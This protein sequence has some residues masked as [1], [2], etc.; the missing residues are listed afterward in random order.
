MRDTHLAI[1]NCSTALILGMSVTLSP[2]LAEP[3]ARGATPAGAIIDRKSGEEVRFVD[4]TDWRN[5][6]LKQDLLGG[7]LLRT[8]AV[9][10]LA[11]LFADHTQVRLGR[12]SALQVKKMGTT[13]DTVL[14]LT[15]GSMWAR[16]QRG[17]QAL[18]VETPAAAAAIRG[19]DWTL[20]VKGD[21]TSLIVL[22]GKI[23]FKNAF[24]SVEVAAGEG[25][26]AS[27]GQA[28]RKL[29]IVNTKDRQQM[30]VYLTLRSGFTFMPA[31][32]LP[33]RKMREEYA[34]ISGLPAETRST[35]DWLTLAEARMAIE[36]QASALD[37]LA[38]L[39][40]RQ[41]SAGQRARI[42]FID[43]LV[44]GSGRRYAE[45]ADLFAKA[46]RGLDPKRRAVAAYGG[47]FARS[48][49]DPNRIEAPPRTISTPYSDIMQA[50]T[51]GFLKDIPA[52]IEVIRQSEARYRDDP[53]LPAVRALL[54]GLDGDRE[55]MQAATDRA[56]S[57]DPENPDA[58]FARATLK[59][60]YLG[61]RKGAV[62][63]FKA[64][65]AQAPGESSAW[66]S[67]GL[68]YGDMGA[69]REQEAALRKAIELDPDDPVG[70]A[71]MALY[72]LDQGRVKDA[73]VMI[74]KALAVDPAFDVALVA[75]GRYFLQTGEPDKAIEDLLAGATAN[76]GYSQA[77]LMLGIGH[78]I[79]G[80]RDPS[81]Q[82]IE[83]ADRLDRN[84]PV[85]A[86]LRT[87]I[88]IDDYDADTAIRNA[89]DFLRRSRAAGGESAAIGA[90]QD[91]GSTLNS[92]FRLQGMNAWGRYYGD[93]TF[94]PFNGGGYIDQMI[95]GQANPYANSYIYGQGA[96]DIADSS[97]GF[98]SRIQG[99]LLDPH[100]IAAP[101]RRASILRS[102]FIETSLGGGFT[103]SGG[104]TRR[105]GELEVQAYGND[106]LPT[107]FAADINWTE[108][109]TSGT[110]QS[111]GAFFTESELLDASV[112]LTSSLTENDRLVVYGSRTRAKLDGSGIGYDSL[113][114]IPFS[115][116]RT[117]ADDTVQTDA[118][119]GL[120][121]TF[122]YRNIANAALLYTGIDANASKRVSLDLP[123]PFDD[124]D[125]YVSSASQR[126][127]IAAVN[128][129]I[130]TDDLTLRYGIEGGIVDTDASF[131]ANGLQLSGG[132]ERARVGL[133]YA[134][135]L[136]DLSPDLK[137]EYGLFGTV[138][139]GGQDAGTRLDPRFGVAWAPA[140]N[141]WLRGAFMRNG[142]DFSTPT[143]SPVATL[144]LQANRFNLTGGSV[145]TFAFEWDAQWSDRF[146]TAVEYQ[147]QDLN[148]FG[149]AY[150]TTGMPIDDNIDLSDGTIDRAS[151][152]TNTVLGGGFG[153][154]T[155][156]A[157]ARSYNGDEDSTG[158]GST[159][160]FVPD[161]T[162]QIALTWVNDAHVKATLAANYVGERT[163]T[164]DGARLNDYWTLDASL[165][166][167]PFDK[168]ISFEAAAYNLLNSDFELTP[169]VPGWGPSFKGMLKVT[170]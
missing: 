126:N 119:V 62:E 141:H 100:M 1:L 70:Y 129:M 94:D 73:K 115:F 113:F 162:G 29:V 156:L 71:N 72:Y 96:A 132:A 17:G 83:N 116:T 120:S 91:A 32:P 40:E 55:A 145:D 22:E 5:A 11:I 31:T 87:A 44:A 166:F 107:S 52:A 9:G 4:L 63:D 28:P 33:Q 167:E 102:P 36:S 99:L 77:Q 144:G 18:T 168:R 148:G 34:R 61:D 74:D 125:L 58:L 7:D 6:E 123:P 90:N 39:R 42:S 139:R 60:E 23:E 2:A 157:L 15:S 81:N 16:A 92:A 130:G 48:L 101:S 95:H 121:H 133:A 67:L 76:P 151:L 140:D 65:I 136:Q 122:G 137:L 89:Q 104:V 142:M 149:I 165:T 3:V 161:T 103:S 51:Q 134:D 160:P 124:D 93:R 66:N 131:T 26:V 21:Q 169:G 14:N 112:N 53:T 37:A 147:H 154:S 45:A 27:I 20:T 150:P 46:E 84:D 57:L 49:A 106:P 69:T 117:R 10:Q 79:K 98:S 88:A 105:M 111:G 108:A 19:T 146:F 24:G 59:A 82:A 56:L 128:H 158:F 30:L 41:L 155:T 152:T 109:P 170:F 13:E 8:N 43:A 153:L 78:Y 80:D 135:V 118:G 68:L 75:R 86:S 50:L 159:L 114:G 38:P 54:H 35:E 25:A 143:L 97:D 164:E 127:Y 64:A 138:S 85:V 47:Y 12:N 110:Y 163:G